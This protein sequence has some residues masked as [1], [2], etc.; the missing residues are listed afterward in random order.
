M[1]LASSR[2]PTQRVEQM[3]GHGL[4]RFERPAGADVARPRAIVCGAG[5]R[6]ALSP[7]ARRGSG[8]VSSVPG[9]RSRGRS[10]AAGR[11]AG[12]G[13]D[14]ELEAAAGSGANA[15]V[16]G[17]PR[18]RPSPA[19]RSAAPRRTHRSSHRPA[20]S[21]I[22]R[23]TACVAPAA[24]GPSPMPGTVPDRAHRR[25]GRVDGRRSR[26]DVGLRRR[27]TVTPVTSA[28]T[29][30]ADVDDEVVGAG[31]HGVQHERAGAIGHR[32]LD[33]HAGLL[34]RDLRRA[35]ARST[36]RGSRRRAV[37]HPTAPKSPLITGFRLYSPE[38]PRRTTDLQA[39]KSSTTSAVWPAAI[40]MSTSILMPAL[41]RRS[42]SSARSRRRRSARPNWPGGRAAV[43]REHEAQLRVLAGR[44]R[45]L[46]ELDQH[47]VGQ[48]EQV[49]AAGRLSTTSDQPASVSTALLLACT[50]TR[51]I[52]TLTAS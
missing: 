23:R 39:S 5:R 25:A 16:D 7:V 26:V 22:D 42:A 29:W 52:V 27:M 14:R 36:A 49:D 45:G 44:Q 17:I 35:A 12:R 15:R 3:S 21:G 47:A 46:P 34:H 37:P 43:G 6:G 51:S 9:A 4:E 28:V 31:R 10:P 24:H 30:P 33:R 48:V 11:R 1:R 38:L 32:R 50:R 13:L 19:G 41:R 20:R 40:S 8:N 2:A 18:T